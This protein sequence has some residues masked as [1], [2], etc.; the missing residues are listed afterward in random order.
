M[1]LLNVNRKNFKLKIEPLLAKSSA[2]WNPI[3]E[4]PPVITTI[5]PSSLFLD[6]HWVPEK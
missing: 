1:D 2:V 4:L 5:L 6:L 3:P